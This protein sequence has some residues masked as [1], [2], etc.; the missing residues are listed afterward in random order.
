MNAEQMHTPQQAVYAQPVAQAIQEPV[1]SVQLVEEVIEIK[2][3]FKAAEAHEVLMQ[4]SI[5]EVDT[6]D[7]D[8]PAYMRKKILE[9]QNKVS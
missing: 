5:S 4:E 7:L 6:N 3:E 2:P 9:K 1:A 8:V